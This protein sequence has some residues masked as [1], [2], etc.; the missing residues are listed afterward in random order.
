MLRRKLAVCPFVVVTDNN[1][2]FLTPFNWIKFAQQ[3]T[4]QNTRSKCYLS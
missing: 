2:N 1:L 3:R 4:C